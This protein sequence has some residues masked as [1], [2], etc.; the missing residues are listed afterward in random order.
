MSTKSL[1]IVSARRRDRFGASETLNFSNGVNVLVGE[2]N[3]GKT[4][5]LEIID[6][7]LGDD[8]KA[9]EKLGEVIFEK[10]ES[11]ELYL[12]IGDDELTVRRAWH[13]K[14][15]KTKLFVDD[16]L[17]EISEFR[18]SLMDR[19]GIPSVSY[20]Q[21]NPQ[22]PRTWPQLGFRSL[23]RHM[24]R[25]QRLWS[26]LADQQYP[27]EQHASILQFMGIAEKLYSK[28]YG[29]LIQKQK[30][31][32]DLEAKRDLFIQTLNEVSREIVSEEELGFAVT[33]D[34]IS[35]A[36][37]R[38]QAEVTELN[39][40]RNEFVARAI[41]NAGAGI[42]G[43]EI[44]AV[45]KMV[46]EF[47]VLKEDE[48]KHSEELE[49]VNSRLVEAE[50]FQQ[51][52][53]AEIGRLERAR[54]AGDVLASL[55]VTHCPVCDQSI[56]ESSADVG[57]YC[58]LCRQPTLADRVQVKDPSKRLEF[59]LEQLRGEKKELAEL[60][61]SLSTK[62]SAHVER[63]HKLRNRAARLNEQLRPVRVATA[64]I[65][66]AEV[67]LLDNEVGR[68][69]ERIDQLRRIRES[70]SR[71]DK[72]ASEI[73]RIK[74]RVDELLVGVERQNTSLDFDAAGDCISDGMNEY[75]RQLRFDS[76]QMWSQNDIQFRIT[77]DGFVVRVGRQRWSSQLGGTMVIYFLLAYHYALL[78]M[79]KE[80]WSRIPGFL[81]L[82]FPAEIEGEKVADH[83]NF[84]IE[85]FISLCEKK[86]YENVEVIVAGS[87]FMGLRGAHKHQFAEVW[88]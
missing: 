26:D 45:S 38:L 8:G 2:P 73:K 40:Q 39:Y 81:M 68:R 50:Q 49:R 62:R 30:E 86:G 16:E 10:Y 29:E 36:T 72:I 64:T 70:L 28:E 46:E 82:D 15:L 37:T 69:N 5:W 75:V 55:R 7:L 58:F 14:G 24:Y 74:G 51:N 57:G 61:E 34:A 88:K 66:P 60:I 44:D 22:G 67:S 84:V 85:P 12:R 77:R 21:G 63:I 17:C 1:N 20:P 35:E 23:F 32:S 42:D 78:K 83:E 71:R 79:S 53:T 19:L 65:I 25:R 56:K 54:K 87:D 31:I 4:R 52:I 9:E 76:K 48:R 33:P 6:F 18:Q 41:G 80:P 3:T 11:A 43:L 59:E 27:S 47:A 13:E